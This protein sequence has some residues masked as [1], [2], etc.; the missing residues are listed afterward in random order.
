MSKQYVSLSLRQ[1][2]S[3]SLLLHKLPY[4]IK[5]FVVALNTLYNLK[6]VVLQSVK[7]LKFHKKRFIAK[8]ESEPFAIC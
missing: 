5:I 6:Q 7:F 8:V 3:T 2:A 4:A 1:I